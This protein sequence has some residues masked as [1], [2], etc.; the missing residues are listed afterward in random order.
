MVG[1]ERAGN[2]VCAADAASSGRGST[3][4]TASG[5][6]S[7]SSGIAAVSALGKTVAAPGIL[8][9]GNAAAKGAARHGVK[10][11]VGQR[12]DH[13]K[14]SHSCNFLQISPRGLGLCWGLPLLRS[15]LSA[16]PQT[17]P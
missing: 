3:A 13:G 2:P 16:T 4:S 5:S 14:I 9:D 15:T 7:N 6:T 8:V 17:A 10:L 12:R 11:A 1:L